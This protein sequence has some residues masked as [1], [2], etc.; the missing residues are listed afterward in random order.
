MKLREANARMNERTDAV[1]DGADAGMIN[2]DSNR[3]LFSGTE[4]DA[5]EAT[6]MMTVYTKEAMS[7]LVNDDIPLR[8]TLNGL[9]VQTLMVGYIVGREAG[10]EEAGRGVA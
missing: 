6:E 4:I 9:V 1:L 5:D 7:A 10:L 3:L 8:A 2:D